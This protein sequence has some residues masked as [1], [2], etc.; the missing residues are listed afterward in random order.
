MLNLLAHADD[1]VLL[2]PSWIALQELIT[3]LELNMNYIGVQCNTE[4]TVCMVFNPKCRIVALR[5][6]NILFNNR[7]LQFVSEF[8]YLGHI[9]NNLYLSFV[10][11]WVISLTISLKMM[12]MIS[13]ER[14]A[15]CS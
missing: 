15:T 8:R 2:A 7:S 1:L 5:F 12:M 4:K 14:F 3:V 10:T 9:I 11:T 6:P 13:N